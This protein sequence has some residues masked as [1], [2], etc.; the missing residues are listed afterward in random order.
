M[1][2]K[3]HKRIIKKFLKIFFLMFQFSVSMLIL[4][5]IAQTNHYPTK[6]YQFIK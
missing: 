1:K 5:G 2:I 3:Y 4:E 6:K